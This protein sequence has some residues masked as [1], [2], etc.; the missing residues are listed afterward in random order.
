MAYFVNFAV[1]SRRNEGIELLPF[2]LANDPRWRRSGHV[3][4][5]VNGETYESLFGCKVVLRFA[6]CVLQA[7]GLAFSEPNKVCRVRKKGGALRHVKCKSEE[8]S[9]TFDY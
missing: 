8:N 3:Q 4:I 5:N 6:E 2:I 7:V 1:T 9:I